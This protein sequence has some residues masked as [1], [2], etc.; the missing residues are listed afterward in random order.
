MAVVF[1]LAASGMLGGPGVGMAAL[2]E[3]RLALREGQLPVGELSALLENHLHLPRLALGGDRMI[4][5]HSLAGSLFIKALDRSIGQGC[6]I[7]IHPD[8]LVLRF[9]PEKLPASTDAARQAIR[10]FTAVAAPEATAAQ[11]REYGLL[12]PQTVDPLRPMVILIHG[13]DCNRSNWG[14]MAALLEGQGYQ[15]GYFSYPSDE[16]IADSGAL[17]ARHMRALR[18]QFPRLPLDM[19]AH[20]M[21]A[22]VARDYVEGDQYA[23]GIDHLILLAP[24]NHG[25]PWAGYRFLLEVQEHYNLWR[26]NPKWHWTWMITDG[27]GEAG[28]DLKPQSAFLQRLNERPRRAGVQYTILAGNRSSFACA[29][30]AC[31]AAPAGWVP[32]VARQWWGIRQC[33][34][35]LKHLAR[36]IRGQKATGDGP[37]P[38]KSTRLQGVADVIVLPADHAELYCAINGAPPAAWEIIRERLA[39]P[40]GSHP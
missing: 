2:H 19:V 6:A 5:L 39:E 8:A 24:P 33:R 14:A 35:G 40:A 38:L 3:V 9:D 32:G 13:L 31:V 34:S 10:V 28:R 16:P 17:L 30:A 12:L 7:E 20:S 23:G 15:V 25:S 18:E 4:D 21:G 29:E 27:V 37:V 22:L 36:V 26:H 1:V 11:N